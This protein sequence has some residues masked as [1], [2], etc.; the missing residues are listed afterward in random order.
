VTDTWD[1]D[2]RAIARALGADVPD[3]GAR[4][5]EGAVADYDAVLAFLPFDEVA[6]PRDLE[7]RVV[8]AA[9]A[10]RPAAV[11]AIDGKRDRGRKRTRVSGRWLGAAAAA[12]AAAAIVV[13]LL[14]G[15]TPSVPGSPA[16]RIATAAATGDAAQVRTASGT[17]HGILRTPAGV[18]GGEALLGAQGSG[19][20]TGL[21]VP[22]G[23]APT[24]WLW[25][26]TGPSPVRVGA[27]PAASTVH[28]VVRGDVAAV[29]G[30]IISTSPDAPEPVSLRASLSR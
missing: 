28:F 11:R 20:L 29:R 21:H 16:G 2:D 15:R 4:I 9:L 30:V 3:V 27:L 5:D 18:T 10:Q 8:A 22:P 13:V 23:G 14:A 17:R 26:D 19:Y 24:S 6:P 7:D 25:L 12:V 1:H